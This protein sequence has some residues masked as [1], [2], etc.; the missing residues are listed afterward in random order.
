MLRTFLIASFIAAAVGVGVYQV[1]SSCGLQDAA[2]ASTAPNEDHGGCG[3][4]EE[5]A[6]AAAPV[7]E[8]RG[9]AGGCDD[10]KQG[11]CGAHAEVAVAA[12]PVEEQ[13]GCGA[14]AAAMEAAAVPQ[15]PH[16][17]GTVAF[18]GP[19]PV[20]AHAVCPVMNKAFVVDAETTTSVHEGK[21]YAFCCDG[22]K[23]VF[24]Q[25]P[26]RHAAAYASR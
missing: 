22:C 17:D 21:T 10:E 11:G 20:G 8:E 16:V 24:D 15:A 5:V 9:C 4:H 14:H 2:L 6:V 3:A 7:A 13:G 26:A 19:P 12:E 25:D 18:D 23:Q 1:R